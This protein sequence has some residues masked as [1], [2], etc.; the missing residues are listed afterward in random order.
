MKLYRLYIFAAIVCTGLFGTGCSDWLDYTP[1]DKQT[2]DKQ[3]STEEGF[4][5]AVNRSEEHTSELQSP[6]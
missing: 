3:F 5:N 1:E 2:Y 4:H 6:R